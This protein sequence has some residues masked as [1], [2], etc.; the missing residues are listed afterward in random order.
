MFSCSTLNK[1]MLSDMMSARAN[2]SEWMAAT[3][4]HRLNI[5]LQPDLH[6]GAANV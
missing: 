4:F 5:C 3:R 6:Y 1:E 2:V